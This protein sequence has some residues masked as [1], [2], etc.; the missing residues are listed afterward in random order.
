MCGIAGIISPHKI[1]NREGRIN[2][3]CATMQRRGP[4]AKGVSLIDEHCVLGHVRLS[5]IDLQE[6]S[7][8]PMIDVSGRYVISYNGEIVNYREIRE[9]L[10][11]PFQTLSDTEVILASVAEY[12]LD[13]FLE[14]SVGMYAFILY[15][16]KTRKTY[17]VRDRFGIKPLLYTIQNETL[18]AASEIKGLLDSGLLAAELN[19]PAIDEYLGC[20]YVREPYTFFQ[21]VFQVP[22][23][24]YLLFDNTLSMEKINYYQ[25]PSLNF[26]EIYNEKTLLE[27]LHEKLLKTVNR[28]TVSD[29]KVGSYLSGG[30]DSS[31]LTAFMASQNK[32]LDT[33]T[34]GFDDKETNEFQYAQMV[35]EKYHT[36]HRAFSITVE[37]YLHEDEILPLYKGAPLGVPNE[38]LLSIMTANLAKDI[39]VVLSGEGAD[40][41]FGGYGRIFRSPFDYGNHGYSCD[42]FSFFLKRYE[43]IPRTFRDAY[44][45][46]DTSYRDYFDEIISGEFKKYRNEENVFRFFHNYHIQGLLQR[47]DSCTMRSSIESR[48]P[49]LDHELVD[50]VYREIPYVLKLRWKNEQLR[51]EAA[52]LYAADYSE[53]LDIPKYILKKVSEHYLPETVIYRKKQGF[54]VPLTKNIDAYKEQIEV[55]KNSHWLSIKDEK[56]FVD[57]IYK[58]SNPG[59]I[60]WMFVCVEQFISLYFGKEWRY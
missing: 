39:T 40:E 19:G 28:W 48:P 13:W 55:L 9:K 21:G 4:D 35:A 36:N 51:Q 26:E 45:Q 12:G 18:I 16:K 54:P 42:F 25:L 3:M 33:Y 24:T 1:N 29:V 58:L 20:R 27:T 44:L 7:N 30:V 56:L 5:I 37:E 52:K 38:S 15:D 60:L 53:V 11:Y 6:K 10:N 8:Q 46:C 22:H 14:Q 59:Q 34:I 2:N 23:A 57:D 17:L 31:L 50:F 32:N 49:F 41:L 47:L 43:Y